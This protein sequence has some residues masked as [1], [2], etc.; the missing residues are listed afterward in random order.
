MTVQ[1][2]ESSDRRDVFRLQAG[3][4]GDELQ[5]YAVAPVSQDLSLVQGALTW[6]LALP[7]S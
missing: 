6:Y 1:Y 2:T 5:M 7:S 4:L 3:A